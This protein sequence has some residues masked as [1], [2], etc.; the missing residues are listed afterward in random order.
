MCTSFID[1][2]SILTKIFSTVTIKCADGIPVPQRF[3]P[4][5]L[6]TASPAKFRLQTMVAVSPFPA[7]I[8]TSS[9][10]MTQE[11]ELTPGNA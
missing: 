4:A 8:P 7:K 5:T 10:S 11:Y 3:S 1:A 9:G 2:S 6:M